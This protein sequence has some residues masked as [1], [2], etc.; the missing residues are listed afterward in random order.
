MAYRLLARKPETTQGSVAVPEMLTE[1]PPNYRAV[2]LTTDS[3]TG[4]KACRMAL[5]GCCHI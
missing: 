1:F 5:D 3:W 4:E 2:H